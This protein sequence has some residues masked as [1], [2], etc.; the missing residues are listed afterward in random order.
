MSSFNMP[1]LGGQDKNMKK[2]YSYIQ[3]LNEQLR[4]SLSNITPENNFTKDSFLKYQE[5][6]ESISQ[7]EVTMNGFI[8]QFTNL[9]ESTETS[10][11]VLNGQIALK[12]S[13]DKLCSEISATSDAITFK[14]GYLVIDTNN[15]KLYKDGTASFSGTING[16]SIN[17]NDKFKVSSSGAV[18]VDAITYADTIT[19][20]GLLYTNYMRISGNADVSGTLTA[21]TVTVSSIIASIPVA[22]IGL[23]L[24]I[25]LLVAIAYLNGRLG[26]IKTW[27]QKD[28]RQ[29]WPKKRVTNISFWAAF[30]VCFL[31]SSMMEIT[32]SFL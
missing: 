15:F 2:V 1:A 26:Y 7:L 21:N 5:T 16:G 9:K 28:I 32:S 31:F 27:F 20:Q 18:S 19:T 3:M 4:Y 22:L 13:K 24:S 10:I 11:R 12:V 8:S 25:F 17:I 6:D 14:T 30:I 23:I 29:T